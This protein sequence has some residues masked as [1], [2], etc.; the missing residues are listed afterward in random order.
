MNLLSFLFVPAENA[1][2]FESALR[3]PCDCVI[4]DLEDG[5]HPSRRQTAREAMPGF[6]DMVTAAGKTAAV[7]IN[8]DLNSAVSDLRAVIGP[9]LQLVVLPKVEH[10]RDVVL[11]AGLIADLERQAGVPEGQT[12]LLLL[13]ESP[14][15]LPRLP[16][17]AAA[18]PRV[19]GMMLGSEDF[20]LECGTLPTP[21]SL[22]LPSMLVLHAAR[23]AKIQPIGFIGSIANIG[24]VEVFR[25]QLQRAR[26]LGFC[27]AIVIHPKFLDA[28]NEECRVSNEELAQAKEVVVAFEAAFA[29]GVGAMKLGDKMIDKPIYLRALNLLRESGLQVSAANSRQPDTAQA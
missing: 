14:A 27:G 15:A 6:L 16:E 18:H 19:M 1:R 7:R 5:T 11:L 3:K 29:E 4:L 13:I 25:T 8:G 26:S 17:I 28:I 21:E 22:E 9:D 20:S 2:L 10:A 23:A 24:E 12:R